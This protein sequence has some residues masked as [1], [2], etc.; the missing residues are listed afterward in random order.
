MGTTVYVAAPDPDER[1]WLES[2]LAPSVESVR[3]FDN[4]AALLGLLQA[5][6]DA[7]LIVAVEPDEASAVALVRELRDIGIALPVIALGP[8]SAFRTAVSLARLEYTD[9]IERPISTARIRAAVR[10]A[11]A[12]PAKPG[13][14][15]G[16]RP[17]RSSEKP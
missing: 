11:C 15:P 17:D 13:G 3:A 6:E 12:A 5:H 8:S 14:K 10:R 7:C 9:Y 16:K 1:R 4:A 2:V